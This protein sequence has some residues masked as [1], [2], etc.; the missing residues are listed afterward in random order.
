MNLK[1]ELNPIK[2]ICLSRICLENGPMLIYGG[3]NI[4]TRKLFPATKTKRPHVVKDPERMPAFGDFSN[5]GFNVTGCQKQKRSKVN[6]KMTH[7]HCKQK[8][9]HPAHVNIIVFLKKHPLTFILHRE[10]LHF[11]VQME[12]M[13]CMMK[14]DVV[15]TRTDTDQIYSVAVR[16]THSL[17]L[18]V[19][20]NGEPDFP[21]EEFT[22]YYAVEFIQRGEKQSQKM[23]VQTVKRTLNDNS[24]RQRASLRLIKCNISAIFR[25]SYTRAP[26]QTRA[27]WQ[28][29]LLYAFG[30]I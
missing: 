18:A 13:S 19:S 12:C 22:S 23:P 4:C 1:Q 20:C 27:L 9:A 29:E 25:S 7:C 5:S 8:S 3:V 30:C 16:L 10:Q 2:Q 24:A 14:E 17:A 28:F 21:V 11:A 6:T 15:D 26:S